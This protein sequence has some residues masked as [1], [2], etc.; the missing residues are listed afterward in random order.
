[1]SRAVLVASLVLILAAA[2][3]SEAEALDD[4]QR[5]FARVSA[6]VV[7][8][9]AA[10]AQG[11]VESQGSGVVVGDGQ[12]ATNCHVIREAASIRVRLAKAE[13]P[14]VWSH[15]LPGL[16]LCMMTVSGLKAGP[17]KL[18]SSQGLVVGE[19]VY[20]I[21]NPLGFGPAV[22]TGL[23]AVAEQRPP[24]PLLVATAQQSPGSSGGGLFDRE[25]NLLGITTATLGTGQNLNRIL[26]ADAVADLIAKGVP[27]P[28]AP[29]IPAPERS[30]N[31]EAQALQQSGHWAELERLAQTW[32]RAQPSSALPLV[33]L[34][35]AQSQSKRDTEAEKNVRS[36]LALDEHL[37]WGWLVLAG[38]LS[39]QGRA[40][41]AEQALVQAERAQPSDAQPSKLRADWLWRK[42]KPAEA[43]PWVKESLRK[44]PGP[45]DAW[46][47]LGKIEDDLGHSAPAT[48]AFATALRLGSADADVKRRLAALSAQ[49]GNA[50]EAIR[51]GL[52]K[53][54]SVEQESAT[55]LAIGVSE[56]K[57]GRL[58]P[59]EDAIR[60]AIAL[61]PASAA[62]WNQ[63][64]GV[65]QATNRLAEAEDAFT[66]AIELKPDDASAFANRAQVRKSRKRL[67]LARQDARRAVDLDPKNRG[68]WSAYGQV[69]FD[70]RD[71][72]EASAAFEKMDGLAILSPDDL[73]SWG[74]SLAAMGDLDGALR[75]VKK[76]EARDPRLVRMCLTMAKVLGLR[77]DI[78]GSLVYENRALEVDPVLPLA[79]S[80]KGYALMKLGRLPQALEALETAVRLDPQLSNAWINLGE[81]QMRS[82]NLGRAIEAL[83]KAVALAPAAT[84][85]Q[86]FLAQSYLAVRLPVKSREQMQKVLEEHPDFAPALGVLTL[87]YLME[88]NTAAAA[89]P[90]RQLKTLS[91]SLARVVRDQASAGGIALDALP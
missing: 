61:S 47:L 52:L 79:W 26:T 1:M 86:V 48:R 72:R 17:V 46:A 9:E 56:M 89:A 65:L 51:L 55:R 80:G 40:D 6:S 68:A 38:S 27:P 35:V 85:A 75:T 50:D 66:K 15:R 39:S 16:D 13:L 59:A 18:R 70:V 44:D 76:A 81:A 71:F 60:K 21:G 24:Y 77:G 25:G 78:E 84:D 69:A 41:E 14:A 62:A 10:D 73:V 11:T 8:V 63:L 28:A 23:I 19:P 43:L 49:T 74:E 58:G 7:T 57:Q 31:D 67:D 53:D 36:A 90:Y 64:G 45:G 83:E 54:A 4:A 88:G 37:A 32:T 30:W 87:A 20:A 2:R 22:S 91:P 3:A 33:F 82:H 29:V 42:G 5:V 34:G 12:V